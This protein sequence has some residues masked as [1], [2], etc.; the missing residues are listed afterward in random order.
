MT[1][2]ETVA[3]IGG[4]SPIGGMGKGR[5]PDD[6]CL[7]GFIEELRTGDL[8]SDLGKHQFAFPFQALG[9]LGIDGTSYCGPEFSLS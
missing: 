7:I 9:M 4:V 5:V 1:M 2:F 3:K 8:W 6:H